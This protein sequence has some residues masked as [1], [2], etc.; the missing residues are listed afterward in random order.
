MTVPQPRL[1]HLNISKGGSWA[2]NV[3][4][5]RHQNNDSDHDN[6]LDWLFCMNDSR[7]YSYDL[8]RQK[9]I[10]ECYSSTS[11]HAQEEDSMLQVCKMSNSLV[12]LKTMNFFGV[13]IWGTQAWSGSETLPLPTLASATQATNGCIFL[14]FFTTL[15]FKS[16]KEK[17]N[18]SWRKGS[19]WP[20]N[21]SL[22]GKVDYL[23]N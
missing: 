1:H 22:V 4:K 6:N 9:R 2:S 8:F 21:G 11:M 13:D 17:A 15:H 10:K 16:G 12:C 5:T 7:F 18:Y 14:S 20:G 3:T 19:S 23:T